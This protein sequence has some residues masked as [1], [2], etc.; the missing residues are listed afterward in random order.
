VGAKRGGEAAAPSRPRAGKRLQAA[1]AA[2]AA[3]PRRTKLELLRELVAP[4]ARWAGPRPVYLVVDSAYAGR[5][6]LEGRPANVHVISRLRPDAA[7]WAPPPARQPGQ[8]GRPRRR[9]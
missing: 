8:K 6:L 9:G 1:R 2:H 5:A 7:L 4:V 3:A